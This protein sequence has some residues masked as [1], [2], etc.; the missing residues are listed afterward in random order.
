L[1]IVVDLLV[2]VDTRIALDIQESLMRHFLALALTPPALPPRM[3]QPTA[4][5]RLI[6]S[7]R[8]AQALAP[9]LPSTWIGAIQLP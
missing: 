4:K 2:A 9:G 3:M 7:T 6:A 5:A 8:I 1:C